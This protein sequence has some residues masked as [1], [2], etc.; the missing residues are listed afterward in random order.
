MRVLVVS[1]PVGYLGSGRGGGVE[2]TGTMIVAGLLARGHAV[3][4][5]AAEGSLLPPSCAAA[6]LWQ[7]GGVDQPS[8]QHCPRD[9]AVAIPADAL[10]PR[11]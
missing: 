2:H 1:T 6:E 4:V 5:L 9:T 11:F 8:W 3:T 10:L 7:E